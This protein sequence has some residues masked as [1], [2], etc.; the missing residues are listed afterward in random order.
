MDWDKKFEV[1]NHK[2]DLEHQVFFDL[3][4]AITVAEKQ[5]FSR[6]KTRRLIAETMKYAEFHFLSEENMMVDVGYPDFEAH[7]AQHVALMQHLQSA[8][9]KFEIGGSDT[10]SLAE[11]LTDWFVAHTS[12][13]DKKLAVYIRQTTAQESGSGL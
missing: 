10:R 9:V 13:E 5:N 2:I 1:G 7:H 4:Q 8:V 11:F 6:D 12:H 3:V